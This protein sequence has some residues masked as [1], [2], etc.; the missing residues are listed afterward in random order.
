ML[1]TRCP[2]R[3]AGYQMA[4]QEAMDG[5]MV[6]FH[7]A[8]QQILYSNPT[9]VVIWGLCDGLRTVSDIVELLSEAYP[10]SAVQIMTDV[11]ETLEALDQCGAIEWL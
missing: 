1:D 4:D 5:E 8:T 11:S 9:G 2:R 7:P 3:A 10:D 6:L